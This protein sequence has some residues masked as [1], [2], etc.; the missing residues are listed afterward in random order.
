MRFSKLVVLA[1]AISFTACG[2]EKAPET[3]PATPAATATPTQAGAPI[4]GKT[5][6]VQMTGS[7]D[8]TKFA[9][10]PAAITIAPGDGI[11]FDAVS[12]V[13]HNVAFDV[14]TVP[15]EA[16]AVL[17]ANMP[18]QDLGEL[19]SKLLQAGESITISFANVPPGTY[20]LTCT[21]HLAMG[22]K[23]TVTVK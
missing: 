17:A 6:V 13:P 15:A 22:M 3:P 10:S 14:A 5:E 12:G 8:G 18:N 19:S 20:Q 9:F 7:A 23:M 16:K 1:S 11:R 4:T 2:G 21:P